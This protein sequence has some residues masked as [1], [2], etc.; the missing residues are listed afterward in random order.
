[1]HSLKTLITIIASVVVIANCS[2]APYATQVRVQ[3]LEAAVAITERN[4]ELT[5]TQSRRV[6]L[7]EFNEGLHML[8][9]MLRDIATILAENE[10]RISA[11]EAQ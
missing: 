9:D 1:M 4:L 3:E 11:L 8:R 7:V 6:Q 2:C 10:A 5:P